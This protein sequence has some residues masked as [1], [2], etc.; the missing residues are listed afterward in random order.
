MN[1]IINMNSQIK[2]I[3]TL[4]DTSK[5]NELNKF[6]LSFETHDFSKERAEAPETTTCTYTP[7]P[8]ETDPGQAQ[9]TFSKVCNKKSRSLET[10][11]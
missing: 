3:I 9:Y 2:R 1:N 5:A 6:F 8:L 10:C 7:E 4:D 11:P